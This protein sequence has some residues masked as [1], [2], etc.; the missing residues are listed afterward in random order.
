MTMDIMAE[1]RGNWP[2]ILRKLGIG[3]EYLR[4]RHGPCP[5]CGGV[6]RYRF[7][8][9]DD[10]G[11]YYCN[12][13]G[14]GNGMTMVRKLRSVDFK[15]AC[16]II[17]GTGRFEPYIPPPP[18]ERK[19]RSSVA[20]I[21]LAMDHARDPRVVDEYLTRRG[22]K[23]RSDVLLGDRSCP[24]YDSKTGEFL[25]KYPALVAPIL[26]GD[27]TL[28]SVQRIY[29][30][31]V[32]PRKKVMTPVHTITGAAVHLF[33]PNGVLGVAEGIETALAAHQLYNKPVW[34]TISEGGMQA[35][36]PPPTVKQVIIFGDNDESFVGQQ[37]AYQLA[38][39]L[40]QKG[41]KADVILPQKAGTDWL[42]V[43]NEGEW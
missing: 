43:L 39:K 30:A 4:N 24:Y 42:D 41:F 18:A 17:R 32:E 29:D 14:P 11:T 3:D 8:N 31:P 16:D 40:T 9:L 38:K 36:E 33:R 1:A 23:A 19:R 2:M 27:D 25:G 6:D 26:A 35:F 20:R 5:L 21:E 10:D 37:A 34:A 15:T 13:C 12:Q 22:I 7:D 28:E